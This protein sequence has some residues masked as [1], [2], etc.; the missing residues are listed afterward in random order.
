MPSRSTLPGPRASRRRRR[1]GAGDVAQVALGEVV[2]LVAEALS[3]VQRQSSATMLG[4]LVRLVRVAAGPRLRAEPDR[5]VGDD[6][7]HELAGAPVERSPRCRAARACG[8]CSSRTG[9]GPRSRTRC[10]RRRWRR[11]TG[12]PASRRRTSGRAAPCRR[13]SGTACPGRCSGSSGPRPPAW[14]RRGSAC[15][16][17]SWLR[18]AGRRAARPASGPRAARARRPCA[19][20]PARG[21]AARRRARARAASS[22]WSEPATATHS[23]SEPWP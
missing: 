2:H 11:S 10:T 7:V 18:A 4:N 12:S 16:N 21:R 17:R 5:P 6:L 23:V 3:P 8:P 14:S 19:A 20:A 1:R 9:R 13:A 22:P 15:S